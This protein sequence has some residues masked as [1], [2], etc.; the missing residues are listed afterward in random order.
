MGFKGGGVG[1][2]S[3]Q[4]HSEIKKSKCLEYIVKE[5]FLLSSCCCLDWG[6]RDALFCFIVACCV[7]GHRVVCCQIKVISDDI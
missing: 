4:G 7:K 3:S 5:V 1:V 6:S 2:V